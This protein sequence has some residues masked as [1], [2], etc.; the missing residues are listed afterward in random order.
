MCYNIQYLTRKKLEYAE[1]VGIEDEETEKLMEEL[2]KF[3][4]VYFVNGFVHPDIPVITN[5]DPGTIQMFHWG[6]VP[7]WTKDAMGMAKIIKNTLNARGETI[8]EKPS[9]RNSAKKKRCLV[10]LDGFYEYHH[11]N[12]L[13]YPFWIGLKAK[14]PFAVA[15]L[16]EEWHHDGINM[17]SVS[18]VTCEGNPLMAN[19]HNNPALKKRGSGPRMPVILPKE[20]QSSWIKEIDPKDLT[21]IAGLKELIQPFP[22]SEMEAHTAP[23]LVGNHG[24]GNSISAEQE[25]EYPEL[26]LVID[27][28]L[29]KN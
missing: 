25:F 7:S 22:E 12:G 2:E 6:L 27:D 10:L 26:A 16:W 23:P 18:I 21:E 29:C 1:H 19:I 24:V 28:I 13:K 20:L 5:D 3:Q 17:R 14:K 15:G 4:E 8:F 11:F 9:F